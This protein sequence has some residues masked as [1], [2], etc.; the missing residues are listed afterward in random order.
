MTNFF[1]FVRNN[2][3]HVAPLL[4]AAGFAIAI[5]F[6][7]FMA[8]YAVYP[9]RDMNGFF[10]RLTDLVMQGK[11]GEAIALCDRYPSKPAAKVAKQALLRAHQPES[12]IAG[13]VELAVANSTRGIARRTSFLA[14]IANV[15]TL[16]G[17]FGTIAGLIHSFEAVGHADAQQKA[18]LLAAGI[19]T[20]MNATMLGLG[21]AI[22]C[23]VAFSFLV[24]RQ[25][26][27]IADVDQA[28]VRSMDVLQ[29]RYYAAESD[30]TGG[31][32]SEESEDELDEEQEQPSRGV[33]SGNGRGVV[34][35]TG[36]GS[37]RRVA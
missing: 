25:N 24:N 8:L 28:A 22:P 7:R 6:E 1:D 35:H 31:R 12:L 26:Q 32:R 19:S 10:D 37:I 33:R 11:V 18:A 23:M 15:A 5:I 4:V 9:I 2:F 14:T 16:L 36:T 30:A 29:Q 21:V 34:S 17:L 3:M 13:G 20:A 27:L